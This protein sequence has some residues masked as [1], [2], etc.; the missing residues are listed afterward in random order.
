MTLGLA[1]RIFKSDRGIKRGTSLYRFCL[2][3]L[4]P[5]ICPPKKGI[6]RRYMPH[7]EKDKG[8]KVRLHKGFDAS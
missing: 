1:E 5:R 7:G 3:R 4:C 2:E 6:L 8:K